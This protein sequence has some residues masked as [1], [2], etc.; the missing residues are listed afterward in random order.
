M[1][2]LPKLQKLKKKHVNKSLKFN[3]KSDL[4][5]FIHKSIKVNKSLNRLCTKK[6]YIVYG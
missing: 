5:Y 2:K 3:N 6:I 4:K 1:L